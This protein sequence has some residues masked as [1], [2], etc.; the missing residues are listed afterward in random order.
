MTLTSL[1]KDGCKNSITIKEKKEDRE[2]EV[3]YY[4][5]E[6]VDE[7]QINLDHTVPHEVDA[8]HLVPLEDLLRKKW[9]TVKDRKNQNLPKSLN[10]PYQTKRVIWKYFN[11]KR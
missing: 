1:Q 5:I 7:S 4:I 3:K 2:Y 10:V 6:N 8:V 11:E 9:I